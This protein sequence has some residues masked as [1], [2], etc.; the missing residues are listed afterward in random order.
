MDSQTFVAAVKDVVEGAAA[1]GCI[2]AYSSGPPGRRPSQEIVELSSWFHALSDRDRAMVQRVARDVAHAAVFG[3]LCVLD[4]VR[5]IEPSEAKGDFELW[6]VKD[7]RRHLIT[8]SS[9]EMLHDLF[10]AG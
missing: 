8:P 4:G 10:S 3:F 9:G 6:F 2:H 7:G 1:D 5:P